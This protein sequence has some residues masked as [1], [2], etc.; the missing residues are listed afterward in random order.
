ML[1]RLHEGKPEIARV[2]IIFEGKQFNVPATDTVIAAVMATGSN[3]N[4]T[5]SISGKH[6]AAYCQM[7]ICHECLME[8]DGVPNQQACKIQVREGMIIKR[9]HGAKDQT[10]E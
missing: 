7:G 6:R 10:N 8:I 9:Q 5:S 4:R 1:K 2:N 3:F